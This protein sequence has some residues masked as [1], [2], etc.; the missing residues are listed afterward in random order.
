MAKKITSKNK[1]ED[2]VEIHEVPIDFSEIDLTEKIENTTDDLEKKIIE[3]NK[4]LQKKEKTKKENKPVDIDFK[5]NEKKDIKDKEMAERLFSDIKQN[6]QKE[7]KSR[8]KEV[9]EDVK[10]LASLAVEIKAALIKDKS[11]ESLKRA[12]KSIDRSVSL[13]KSRVAFKISDITAQVVGTA[14]STGLK[15]F[16]KSF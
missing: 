5:E 11:D 3:H 9:E 2:K 12:E 16:L 13:I 7:L 10:R 1:K 4:N 8:W 14:L 6:L 15:I